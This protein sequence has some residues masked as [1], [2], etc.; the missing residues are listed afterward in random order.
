MTK[1]NETIFAQHLAVGYPNHPIIHDFNARILPGEFIPIL[2][3]NGAG[4]TSLLKTLLG[5]LIPL[6]GELKVLHHNPH[7]DCVGI[8]YMPQQI[9]RSELQHLTA[10]TLLTA[11]IQAHQWGLPYLSKPQREEIDIALTQVEGLGFADKAFGA[12]SGGQQRRIM[13]AQALLGQPKLLLL[14]EPLANLD[15]R[16]QEKFI[17]ILQ[18]L[19]AQH[20]VTILIT[21]H[22]INPLMNNISIAMPISRIIYLAKG[23]ALMGELSHVLTSEKL[24][25]LYQTPMEVV[26]YNGRFFVVHQETGY[27]ENVHCQHV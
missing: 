25:E 9:L 24:T 8:G 1:A 27:L 15:F 17:E 6:S 19:A 12:C 26:R 3:P 11:T 22:D 16:H 18:R 20:R 10:R 13:L 7:Q 21:T 4:K 2:G 23:K 5:V 14:D